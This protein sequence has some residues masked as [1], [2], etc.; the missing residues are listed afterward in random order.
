MIKDFGIYAAVVAI[1]VITLHLSYEPERRVFKEVKSG[2]ALLV[3]NM[4]DG[5]RVI[6]PEYIEGNDGGVWFFNN[7]SAKNCEIVR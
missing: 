1:V 5:E 3:C 2:Q 7:G 4:F 6:D